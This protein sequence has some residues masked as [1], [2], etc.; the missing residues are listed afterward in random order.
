MNVT[1]RM[2]SKTIVLNCFLVLF[3]F[4]SATG[5][6]AWPQ[7]PAS[8]AQAPVPPSVNQ[9]AR[10]LAPL[11]SPEIDDLALKVAAEIEKRRFARVAV[12]GAAGPGNNLT[13]LGP[14]LGDALSEVLARIARGFEVVDRNAL[15]ARLQ[16]ERVAESMLI[17]GA[18]ATWASLKMKADGYV[19]V[20]VE[21]VNSQNIVLAAHVYIAKDEDMAAVAGWQ[22]NMELPK[23][24]LDAA[25]EPLNSDAEIAARKGPIDPA[26]EGLKS[27]VSCIKCPRPEYPEAARKFKHEG[28]ATL[29]ITVTTDGTVQD[30]AVVKAAGYGFDGL[31]VET[32]RSW[33]FTPAIDL[34]GKPVEFR[35]PIDIV[36]QLF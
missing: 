2:R 32:I 1:A 3:S 6:S 23:S 13:K 26:Q 18:L 28:D 22:E 34:S 19:F 7:S 21:S 36:W 11:T 15:R 31:A 33:R 5:A 14:V 12:F 9:A 8:A 27:S 4:G 20:T 25:A 24:Y 29:A 35:T 16:Q 17:D 30:I 10:S